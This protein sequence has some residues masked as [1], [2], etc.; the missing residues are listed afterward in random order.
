MSTVILLLIAS[1]A[2]ASA[3]HTV[4]DILYWREKPPEGSTYVTRHGHVM[5]QQQ[6]HDCFGPVLK[7]C[8]PHHEASERTWQRNQ[9]ISR[10]YRC[11]QTSKRQISRH[12]HH[13]VDAHA[14]CV[15][16]IERLCPNMI[17]S[18]TLQ[19]VDEK[20]MEL[21][22]ACKASEWY[23]HQF[24]SDD[25]PTRKSATRH[26]YDDHSEPIDVTSHIEVGDDD[27]EDDFVPDEGS[28]TGRK[29]RHSRHA[30]H[31]FGQYHAPHDLLDHE[32]DL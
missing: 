30:S 9:P 13:F 32:A 27:D 29:S 6:R 3:Y 15:A 2:G 7:V 31:S 23:R 11:M 12:C 20:H 5:P 1:A 28:P 22:A 17:L 18:N 21:T 19:C 26:H 4:E 14:G 8:A 10:L 24:P 16:D 25:H